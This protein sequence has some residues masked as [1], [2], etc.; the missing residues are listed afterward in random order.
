M[1]NQKIPSSILRTS[2]TLV[3]ASDD[4]S[5]CPLTLF[6]QDRGKLIMKFKDKEFEGTYLMGNE[7]EFHDMFVG[8]IPKIVWLGDAECHTNPS[9]FSLYMNGDNVRYNIDGDLVTIRSK[10]KEFKFRRAS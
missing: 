10:G 4:P 1:K 2:W 8:F 3:S 6:F 7:N 9:N 5:P